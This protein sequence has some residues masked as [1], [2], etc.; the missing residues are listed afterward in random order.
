MAAD[1][2][3]VL[4]FIDSFDVQASHT[5]RLHRFVY[6]RLN[7]LLTVV[8]QP[9]WAIRTSDRYEI[10]NCCYTVRNSLR[11]VDVAVEPFSNFRKKL[12]VSESS[13]G[14]RHVSDLLICNQLARLG[15][16][17]FRYLFEW[18]FVFV[19]HFKKV[20]F[21]VHFVACVAQIVGC[22]NDFL[23]LWLKRAVQ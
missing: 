8:K 2:K 10:F 3:D 15:Y 21:R 6:Q 12:S 5:V 11:N 13:L 1:D 7:L 17:F 20:K 18:T 22:R 19:N 16:H 4:G 14:G 23:S 9:Y